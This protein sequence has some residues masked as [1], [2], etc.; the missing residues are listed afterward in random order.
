MIVVDV[1]VGNYILIDFE[2]YGLWLNGYSGEFMLL[3]FDFKFN[4]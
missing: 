3:F 1:F 4:F 2:L